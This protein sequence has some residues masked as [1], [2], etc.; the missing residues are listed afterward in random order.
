MAEAEL[1]RVSEPG[2]PETG[3]T[4][5]IQIEVRSL[6]VGALAR[7]QLRLGD[8][9]GLASYAKSH[10][11]EVRAVVWNEE[12][13]TLVMTDRGT[14]V[15]YSPEVYPETVMFL[16]REHK[17]ENADRGNR[18]WEGEFEPVLFSKKD[19]VK[20]LA[21]YSGGDASLLDSIKTLRVTKRTEETEKML[22]VETDD[23]ERT[24]IE[25]EVTNIPRHFTMQ[26]RVTEGIDAIFEFE[27][28]L[29]KPEPNDYSG[30]QEARTKRIAVRA[31]NARPVLR[32][33]MRNI[34]AR[35][36]EGIPQYYGRFGFK[37]P[38]R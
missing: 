12:S 31:V 24:E 20:F 8:I 18:V 17:R 35:L 33:V 10:A 23:V 21:K 1:A 29:Y 15:R 34:L 9:S 5:P 7:E 16:S 2:L 30:R 38:E 14:E 37:D 4:T 3:T 19:L 28:C 13:V 6:A 11:P 25:T 26:M 27:A 22:D 36:P 32:D